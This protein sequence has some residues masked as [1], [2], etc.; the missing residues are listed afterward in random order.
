MWH[1]QVG[2][3]FCT[4]IFNDF[5]AGFEA[6]LVQP[7]YAMVGILAFFALVHSGLAFLRPYGALPSKS[8]LPLYQRGAPLAQH[9]LYV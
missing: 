6:L 1:V 5:V 9:P 4:D 3:I 2:L 8:T 7:E